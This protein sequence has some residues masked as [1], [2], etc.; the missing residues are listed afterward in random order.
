MELYALPKCLS[1]VYNEIWPQAGTHMSL[2]LYPFQEHQV[3]I[4]FMKYFRDQYIWRAILQ[5]TLLVFVII[6]II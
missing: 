6:V 3:N 5:T 1:E 4:V 2:N